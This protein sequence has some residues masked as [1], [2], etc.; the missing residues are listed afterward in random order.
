MPRKLHE[1]QINCNDSLLGYI[2]TQENNVVAE[3]SMCTHSFSN[4]HFFLNTRP[5]ILPVSIKLSLEMWRLWRVTWAACVSSQH[6]SNSALKAEYKYKSFSPTD[7]LNKQTHMQIIESGIK[8]DFGGQGQ[9]RQLHLLPF[10]SLCATCCKKHG[11]CIV[12]VTSVCE[13]AHHT[14]Y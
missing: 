5:I 6:I 10:L 1:E 14:F 13:L 2:T 7:Y 12:L 8:M 11:A 4:S 9:L 3:Y